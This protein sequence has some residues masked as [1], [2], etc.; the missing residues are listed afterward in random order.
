[1][2]ILAGS[3]APGGGLTG[4]PAVEV[5]LGTRRGLLEGVSHTRS[6]PTSTNPLGYRMLRCRCDCG[7]WTDVR[8]SHFERGK[9]HSC[10]CL[11]TGH[12]HGLYKHPLYWTWASILKRCHDANHQSY[13]Y[14]GARGITVC[15]RWCGEGGFPNFLADVGEK[16][17]WATGGID[18]ID[19]NGNYEPA[20][21]RWST[22][23]QQYHNRRPKGTNSDGTD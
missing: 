6:T 16:P 13:R 7:R 15:D 5:E 11:F 21:C 12:K 14:Y 23:K 19:V 1:M 17:E 22:A 18:R 3:V 10:G 8:A 20:N 9:V 2:F 4:R